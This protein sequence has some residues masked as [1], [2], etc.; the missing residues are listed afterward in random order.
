MGEEGFGLNKFVTLYFTN[1]TLP[2]DVGLTTLK[3][4]KEIS[5]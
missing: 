4:K 1:V 2:N 3:A 5:K